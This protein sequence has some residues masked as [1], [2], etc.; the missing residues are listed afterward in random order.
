[1]NAPGPFLAADASWAE[2]PGVGA[3]LLECAG[4][5]L[6]VG[7]AEVLGEVLLDRVPVVAT[8]LVDHGAAVVGEDDEDRAAVVFGADAADEAGVLES[9]DDA[10]EPTLAVEDSLSELVHA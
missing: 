10:G 8:G 6:D 1:M 2:R 9:V 7:V 4:Q 5:S 3:Q